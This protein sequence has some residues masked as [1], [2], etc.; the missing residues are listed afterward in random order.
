[1]FTFHCQ[2]SSLTTGT[3][4]L[5]GFTSNND[6]V[7]GA[8]TT[9][10]SLDSMVDASTTDTD[11]ANL[12]ISQDLA[13]TFTTTNIENINLTAY[14]AKSVDMLKMTG[15]EVFNVKN[16]TGAVT[17]NN[18]N[19]AT[20]ALSFEGSSTNS[21]IANYKAGTLSGTA[22][23]LTLSLNTSSA[24]SIDADAGFESAEITVNGTSDLDAWTA[25]GVVTA[26]LKGSGNLDIATGLMTGIETLSAADYT[27]NLTTGSANATTGFA[28]GTITGSSAGTVMTLGSGTDNI[29]VVDASAATKSTT[30]KLGAGDDKLVMNAAGTA[31]YVFGE[32][33]NDS[34]S[35]ATTGLDSA[36]VVDGGAGTDTLTLDGSLVNNAMVLK[37]IENVTISGTG[38]AQTFTNDDDATAITWKTDNS[39]VNLVNLAAGSTVSVVT[40]TN[41]TTST[42]GAVTAGFK[43]VEAASTISIASGMTGA[44]TLDNITAATVTLGAASAMGAS[45]ITTTS[46]VTDLTINAT[47]AMSTTG[48]IASTDN[49]LAK[50]TVTGTTAV[51]LGD[52]TSTGMTDVNVT[53]TNGLLTIGGMNAGTKLDAV[54]LTSTANGITFVDTKVIGKTTNASVLDVTM[55]AKNAITSTTGAGTATTLVDIDSTKLGNVSVTSTAG[56]VAL[57]DIGAS[58]TQIG[59]ITI[60]AKGDVNIGGATAASIGNT[61]AAATTIGTVSITSTNGLIELADEGI[62]VKDTGGIEVS[63][64]AATTISGDSSASTATVVRND[65]G[66]ATVTIAGATV[67]GAY[68]NV[69]SGDGVANLTAT[70]T[71]GLTSTIT[72]TSTLGDAET[73]TISLGNATS[74]NSNVLTIDGTVDTLNITGGTGTDTVAFDATGTDS[75]KAGTISLGGGSSDAVDFTNLDAVGTGTTIGLAMNFSSS[76]IYFGQ[77]SAN[78]TSIAS[79]TVAEYESSYYAGSTTAT[80]KAIIADGASLTVSGVEILTG[81]ANDDYIALANTG[82]TVNIGGGVD[83]IIADAGVDTIVITAGTGSVR[84]SNFDFGG[85]STNDNITLTTSAAI[86]N[87]NGDASAVSTAV[88]A[89][90]FTFTALNA[91]TAIGAAATDVAFLIAATDFTALALTSTDAQFATAIAAQLLDGTDATTNLAL[92]EGFIGLMA[93]DADSDGTV[94][95]YSLFQFIQAT[96]ATAS[97]DDIKLIGTFTGLDAANAAAGDFL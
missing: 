64:T 17:L 49:K 15:V 77:G 14:G 7:N 33:G 53:A 78:Q 44:L 45:N 29:G 32:A 9:V 79:G 55:T 48:N 1:M 86:A 69:S 92:G 95:S 22:D 52:F 3:D 84:V 23:K 85:T 47:G 24:V 61:T 6:T 11:T 20:M 83:T 96:A 5:T 50:V 88:N 30:V 76:T 2:T 13:S 42:A 36:D 28:T 87:A 68:V 59:N 73:S 8:L 4:T 63:L 82:M 91:D 56:A 31:M 38:Q 94:D 10:S 80:N 58:A 12:E 19:S 27:G 39:A 74:G 54:T 67:G 40:A 71:G 60:S 46:D 43:A 26:T 16:S 90:G 72:N 66:N 70:N 21:I 89:G 25:P 18:A 93:N 35:A 41:A 75:L 37:S 62:E 97:A 57:G 65:A 81:T 34:I 51:T